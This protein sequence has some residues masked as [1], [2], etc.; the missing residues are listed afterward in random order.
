M[1]LSVC[2]TIVDENKFLETHEIRKN[3]VVFFERLQKYLKLK[4]ELSRNKKTI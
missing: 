4:N 2:E 3:E 1:E